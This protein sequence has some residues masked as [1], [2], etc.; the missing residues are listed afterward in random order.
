MKNLCAVNKLLSVLGILWILFFSTGC[1]VTLFS[2]L[3]KQI[4][5]CQ[6]KMGLRKKKFNIGHK[7]RMELYHLGKLYF[8]NQSDTL[9]IVES[10]DIQSGRI[11]G[12]IWNSQSELKYGKI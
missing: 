6:L 11:F 10:S 5:H 4:S 2:K 8:F 3:S 12:Q 7:V 9:F 1:Q